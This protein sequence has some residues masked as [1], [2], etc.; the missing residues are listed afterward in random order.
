VDGGGSASF[1]GTSLFVNNTFTTHISGA[2]AA[3]LRTP[4]VGTGVLV[5]EEGVFNVHSD[6]SAFGGSTSV[7]NGGVLQGTGS[8][9]GIVTVEAGGIVSAGLSP[10]CMTY[11]GDVDLSAGG[12]LLIEVNGATACSGYDV[13][14]IEGDLI[15]GAGAGGVSVVQGPTPPLD[16]SF[17]QVLSVA[18]VSGSIT[19]TLGTVSLSPATN[20]FSVV[21]DTTSNEI[22]VVADQLVNTATFTNTPLLTLRGTFTTL[23]TFEHAVT[24]LDATDFV[25]N[26][27]VVTDVAEVVPNL[28]Y[29]ITVR[30]QCNGVITVTLPEAAV[31][32]FNFEASTETNN[33]SCLLQFVS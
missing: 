4:L 26:G 31:F 21:V 10:G 28:Q 27:G 25:V 19:G 2:G 12:S 16:L 23:L 32:L 7:E 15:L 9:A 33:I 13:I 11:T 5:I 1:E 22:T 8:L 3:D 24:N 14:T 30:V 29:E 17:G 20:V 18:S 6:S